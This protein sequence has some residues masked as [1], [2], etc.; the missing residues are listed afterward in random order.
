M[1]DDTRA[2]LSANI[3]RSVST[4][5]VDDKDFIGPLDRF[6][7]IANDRRTVVGWQKYRD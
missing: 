3:Q 2:E 7:R 1:L 5:G 4:V 6:E